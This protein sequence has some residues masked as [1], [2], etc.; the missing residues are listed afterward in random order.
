M[1]MLASSNL[2]FLFILDI[3]MTAEYFTKTIFEMARSC[4]PMKKISQTKV[5]YEW[6]ND[7]CRKTIELKFAKEGTDEY[8]DACFHCSKVLSEAYF[9]HIDTVKQQIDNIR[10]GSK[11]WWKLTAKLLK[12][13][14]KQSGIPAI[15]HDNRWIHDPEEKA[16]IFS[17]T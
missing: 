5:N 9:H 12:R 2:D 14:G 10:R 6:L 16:K 11:N 15:K 1:L 8:A 3:H 13:R 7:E 4:I 17:E